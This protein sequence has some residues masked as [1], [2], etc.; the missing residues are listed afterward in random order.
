[1]IAAPFRAHL[2]VGRVEPRVRLGDREACLV[3]AGDQR[4]QHAAL[5]LVG[6]EHNDRLQSEDVHVDGGG[7]AHGRAGF[8]DRLHHDRGLG[9]AEASPAI[10][11][12]HGNAEPARLRQRS[13]QLVRE[14]AARSFAAQ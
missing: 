7:P 10:L 13:M 6:P 3:L 11:R 12:R 14:L 4:R 8:G 1:M 9:D 2:E 5:L